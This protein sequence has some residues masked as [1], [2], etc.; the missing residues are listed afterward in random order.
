MKG[1]R[2]PILGHAREWSTSDDSPQIFWLT[3]VAG[4]GKS[5]IANHLAREWK[6]SGCLVG[7]FFFSREAEQSR[8]SRLFYSTIAQQG[9]SNLGSDLQSLVALG[10]PKL[11]SPVSATLE[12]QY[13]AMFVNPLRAMGRTAIIVIDALDECD[14]TPRKQLI[15]LILSSLPELPYLRLFITSRPETYTELSKALPNHVIKSTSDEEKGSHNVEIFILDSTKNS[16]LQAEHVQKLIERANGLFIWASTACKIVGSLALEPEEILDELIGPNFAEMDALYGVALRSTLSTL[17]V[18]AALLVLGVILVA[19]E[20]LSPASIYLLLGRSASDLLIRKMSSVLR[21]QG[22]DEPVRFFHPTFREYLLQRR[23]DDQFFLD[24]L[25]AH[26][27]L[28]SNCLSL[29]QKR[30]KPDICQFGDEIEEY[31]DDFQTLVIDLDLKAV[32]DTNIPVV[33]RYACRFWSFHFVSCLSSTK[34]HSPK[35]LI[36][37][38]V[39]FFKTKFLD[40]LFV[41]SIINKLHDVPSIL[42]KVKFSSVSTIYFYCL[43]S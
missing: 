15:R 3:D 21:Y 18:K 8:T 41:L 19:N 4:T 6:S 20:P 29:M 35:D 16:S 5:T 2:E 11:K 1:T 25:E 17:E 10:I 28:T 40:W 7:R 43:Y 24:E 30:L 26:H 36:P 34:G 9:I 27:R 37:S 12:E 42:D 23:K 33:L 31:A 14:P 22:H 38:I 13:T 39:E 32:I